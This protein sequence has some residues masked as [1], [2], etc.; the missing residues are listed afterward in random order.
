MNHNIFKVGWNS[1]VRDCIVRQMVPVEQQ[2]ISTT[3]YGQVEFDLYNMTYV[4][5]QQYQFVYVTNNGEYTI[6]GT[7]MPFRFI[8]QQPEEIVLGGR[9]VPTVYTGERMPVSVETVMQKLQGELVHLE[10]GLTGV[11]WTTYQQP[12]GLIKNVEQIMSEKMRIEQAQRRVEQLCVLAQLKSCERHIVSVMKREPEIRDFLLRTKIQ[13]KIVSFEQKVQQV[14]SKLTGTLPVEQ[15]VAKYEQLLRE[16]IQLD[17]EKRRVVLHKLRLTIRDCERKL[18]DLQIIDQE[19]MVQYEQ[20]LKGKFEQ[21]SHV[22]TTG[23]TGFEWPKQWETVLGSFWLEQDKLAVNLMQTQRDLVLLVNEI[24]TKIQEL[25]V[26]EVYSQLR[27]PRITTSLMFNSHPKLMQIGQL[28]RKIAEQKLKLKL[29]MFGQAGWT[30]NGWTTLNGGRFVEQLTRGIWFTPII[31]KLRTIQLH[32]A[33]L[34]QEQMPVRMFVERKIHLVGQII[35]SLIN[36]Q[37][38]V[39]VQSP[40]VF[41]QIKLSNILVQLRELRDRECVE[42]PRFFQQQQ[43]SN[44]IR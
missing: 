1:I 4:P 38:E 44:V 20:S 7:S 13:S 16:K 21:F 24:C 2:L 35:N 33:K 3:Q 23:T 41:D 19:H 9:Y 8:K 17:V 43:Y 22:I 14:V 39:Y 27:I 26:V 37:S 6:L 11:N 34:Q 15:Y 30:T 25:E 42:I 29:Q 31:E 10:Q 28:E 18:R 40:A 36:F 32:L 5:E 12:I